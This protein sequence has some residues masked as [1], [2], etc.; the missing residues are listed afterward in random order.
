MRRAALP[1]IPDL[2]DEETWEEV[3]ASAPVFTVVAP[4][5]ASKSNKVAP[6]SK[7]HPQHPERS[8]RSWYAT[9]QPWRTT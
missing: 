1:D 7:R 6:K 9:W 2:L 5:V 4:K 3:H 8:Y